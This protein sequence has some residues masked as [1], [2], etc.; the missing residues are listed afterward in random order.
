[1]YI[2]KGELFTTKMLE[3]YGSYE[4][5]LST[6][7]HNREQY[8][9]TDDP[10]YEP[11][12]RVINTYDMYIKINGSD[13]DI[14]EALHA[15]CLWYIFKYISGDDDDPSQFMD[16]PDEDDKKGKPKLNL[17]KLALYLIRKYCV[18]SAN[19]CT[20]CYIDD[21][22]YETQDR[23]SKDLVKMLMHIGYSDHTKVK[24][25]VNDIIYRVR[26]MTA[27]FKDFPFNKKA[28]YLIPVRNGVVVRRNIN[29]LLPQ[30][31]VWGFTFSLPVIFDKNADTK[32]IKDFLASLVESDDDYELLIQI[33]AQALLQDEN[34]QQA[35][36]MTGGGSNG[37]STFITLTTRLVGDTN[38]TAVSLQ[39]I[40]ENRFS[41]AELQGKLLN[42]YPDLPKSSLKTTGKF[43][44]LT[45]ADSITVEKKFAQPFKLRNKAVFA[46]S[47]NALPSVDDSSFAFWRRWA[48]LD[49]PFTF[50]VDPTLIDKLAIPQ[51]LSGY[52]NLVIDKMNRIE[53]YGLTRSN[54]VEDAMNMWKK[55]SNSAY[56]YVTD[57]L[58]KSTTEYIK[59]D[60]LYNLYLNYCE[61]NDFTALGKPKFTMEL[62][63]IGA[64][65]G[66]ATEAQARVKVVKG[67][68]LKKKMMP[69]VKPEEESPTVF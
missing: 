50:K 25:I 29:E 13:P 62:E 14:S 17:N 52:L 65:I 21:K 11:Y 33:V 6:I 46:F 4:D 37:K 2:E 9:S 49:F 16:E 30:S 41:A 15:T 53:K 61:E 8:L 42:M 45:G 51:N 3:L 10:A 24:E 54:K 20:Y 67:I 5:T 59:Y 28:K 19:D 34:Y 47:A 12:R 55:R 57:M 31:P 68:K 63:K 27:K 18:V 60:T 23:L 39:E 40:I 48:I 69:E 56:A 1:L 43:K 36:L 26:T 66:H 64:I 35:Y 32:P 7:I 38:I 22:Y 58:E 44:A